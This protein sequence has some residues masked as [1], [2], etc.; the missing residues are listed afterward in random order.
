MREDEGV[1]MS[2]AAPRRAP[3][4]RRPVA[5]LTALGVTLLG[6][7]GAAVVATPAAAAGRTA[8]LVGDLQS[9]LGCPGDWQPD[10]AQTE[11]APTDVAGRYSA[12][13]TLPAGTYAYK[14]ALNDAWDESYG[15]DGGSSNT[16]LVLAG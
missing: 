5:A 15:G 6:L 11:L 16:P 1:A 10:C 8:A 12:D 13:F 2:P 14:V 4:W 7:V 3:R 9:E